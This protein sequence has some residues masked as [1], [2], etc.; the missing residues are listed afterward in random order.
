MLL[1]E[2]GLKK[3]SLRKAI[4]R[5]EIEV[6]DNGK[7]KINLRLLFK[8]KAIFEVLLMKRYDKH[9]GS[10]IYSGFSR[11]IYIFDYHEK[12]FHIEKLG[13]TRWLN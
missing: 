5:D 6:Y 4:E 3:L 1:Q 13:D 12:M 8:D 7:K 11:D 2:R 9:I 10:D